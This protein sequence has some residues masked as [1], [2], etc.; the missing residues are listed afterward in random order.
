MGQAGATWWE[1][2]LAWVLTLVPSWELVWAAGTR[3]WELLPNPEPV[4]PEA[5]EG[6]VV[7]LKADS[8]CQGLPLLPLALVPLARKHRLSAVALYQ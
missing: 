8:A 3:G 1:L 4:G 6:R 5:W 2:K 7:Q